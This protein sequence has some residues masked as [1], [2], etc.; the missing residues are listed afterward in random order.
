[1]GEKLFF[2]ALA[3]TQFN[4][5][6]NYKISFQF[7]LLPAH[8][9]GASDDDD[10]HGDGNLFSEIWDFQGKFVFFLDAKI[11]LWHKLYSSWKKN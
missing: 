8:H 5:Q 1:M 11:A 3:K 7:F 2:G 9:R 6:Y 10:L 4:F